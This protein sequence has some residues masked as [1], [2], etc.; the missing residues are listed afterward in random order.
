MVRGLGGD[1]H[2]TS[3]TFTLRHDYKTDPRLTHVDCW[4]L[5]SPEELDELGLDE[6]VTEVGALVIEWGNLAKRRLGA[7]SLHVSLADSER[8]TQRVARL[9]FREP[10]WVAREAQLAAWLSSSGVVFSE[11]TSDVSAS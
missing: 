4:R 9:D 3:P 8:G 5:A 1:D 11:S 2:V 10:R 7:D 6:V